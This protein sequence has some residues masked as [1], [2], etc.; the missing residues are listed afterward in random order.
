MN[1]HNEDNVEKDWWTGMVY[2]PILVSDITAMASVRD[3]SDEQWTDDQVDLSFKTGFSKLVFWPHLSS[4]FLIQ[5][6]S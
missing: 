5:W 2:T 4:S 6:R 3:I 1:L